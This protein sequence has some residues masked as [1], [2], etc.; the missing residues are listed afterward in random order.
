MSEDLHI[1]VVYDIDDSKL[2]QS[3]AKVQGNTSKALSG[4]SSGSGGGSPQTMIDR[5]LI[6]AGKL[7]DRLKVLSDAHAKLSAQPGMERNL[8]K[9]NQELAGVFNSYK[10]LSVDSNSYIQNLAKEVELRKQSTQLV[11]E[12]NKQQGVYSAH[13]QRQFAMLQQIS[14]QVPGGGIVNKFIG[15]ASEG[16]VGGGLTGAL[17][18]GGMAA[19]AGAAAAAVSALV[20]K[21]GELASRS[22]ELSQSAGSPNSALGQLRSATERT[23]ISKDIAASSPASIGF[24]QALENLK[25]EYNDFTGHAF[26][27]DSERNQ[28]VQARLQQGLGGQAGEQ[29]RRQKEQRVDMETDI[30]TAHMNLDRSIYTQNR[31]Y[32]L[33]LSKF[34]VDTANQVFDLQKSAQRQSQ[35]YQIQKAQFDL[36]FEGQMAA[37]QFQMSQQFALAGFQRQQGYA[38]A[39]YNRDRGDKLQDFGIAANDKKFDFSRSMARNQTEFDLNRGRQG[40]DY[41]ENLQKMALSGADGK[42]FLFASIDMRKQQQRELE[43]FNRQKQYATQDYSTSVSRDQRNLNIGLGRDARNLNIGMNRNA[44]EFGASQQEAQAGRQLQIESMLNSRKWQSLELEI[45]HARALQDINIAA[46]RLAQSIGFSKQGFANQASDMQF[47]QSMA[48]YQQNL[49]DYRARRSQTYSDQDFAG[50]QRA[51]DPLGALGQALK[52]PTFAQALVGNQRATGQ[53]D[54]LAQFSDASGKLGLGGVLG[55]VLRNSTSFGQQ[56]IVAGSLDQKLGQTKPITGTGGG[57]FGLPSN[58]DW[59]GGMGDSGGPG[60]APTFNLNF[61]AGNTSFP[62]IPGVSQDDMANINRDWQQGLAQLEHKVYDDL[63]KLYGG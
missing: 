5:S 16:S 61:N 7:Q 63:R 50:G 21:I 19:A 30:A 42:S 31:D 40:Q 8:A 47:D 58:G 15:G 32:Q 28:A 10:K 37:K 20:S 34:Q 43:D 4:G 53:G 60:Q 9:V 13:S 49:G 3:L 17:A 29:W 25:K 45:G 24:A 2:N 26:N 57:Y 51:T 12:A 6:Q 23:S 27:S 55:D 22:S 14:S 48:K 62:A 41:A 44:T 54:L 46:Q 56:A 35:D 18:G 33:S 39:D 36:N 1:K 38:V 59:F 11:N 52:D